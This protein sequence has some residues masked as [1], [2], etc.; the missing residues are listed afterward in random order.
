MK[1]T[2]EVISRAIK[3]AWAFPATVLGLIM[4]MIACVSGGR[5][6]LHT[7]VVEVWGGWVTWFLEKV[8][9]LEGGAI[10]M[11]IGHVVIARSAADADRTRLHERIHVRQYERLGPVFI[12][13]YFALS[14]RCWW[15]GQDAYYDNPFEREAYAVDDASELHN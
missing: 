5:C 2:H 1:V 12:P 11:T 3:Y 7:G 4:V 13:L 8:V 15:R 10:A 6:R 14:L 9:P